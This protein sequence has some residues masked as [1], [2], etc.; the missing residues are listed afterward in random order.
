MRF[1]GNQIRDYSSS[2]TAKNI[3]MEQN[4]TFLENSKYDYWILHKKLVDEAITII[5]I[6]T[7]ISSNIDPRILNPYTPEYPFPL[8]GH[9]LLDSFYICLGA[10][11]CIA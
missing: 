6:F 9:I 10:L 8:G 1:H 5:H 4:G 2:F 11:S 7:H 3:Q